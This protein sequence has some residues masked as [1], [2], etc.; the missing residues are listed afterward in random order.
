MRISLDLFN[1]G[2]DT[3][4]RPSGGC[5]YVEVRSSRALSPS[6]LP[7]LDWALNPYIGCEHG[8]SYCYVPSIMKIDR[9]EWG[10]LVKIRKLV[11]N[12]LSKELKRVEGVIGLG[13]MTTPRSG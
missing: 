4:S 12:L 13:T 5:R 6:N 7:D 2:I 1:F 10:R 3:P 11:P 9:A 8:C